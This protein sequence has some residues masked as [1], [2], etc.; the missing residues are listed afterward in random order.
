MQRIE[1][2]TRPSSIRC[3]LNAGMLLL[4][5]SAGAH[6][7]TITID[8]ADPE[9]TVLTETWE[10]GTSA[11]GHWDADY[12]Y[13]GTTGQ[14]YSYGEVEWRPNMPAGAYEVSIYYPQ[15]T[16]RADNAPFTVNFMG[17]SHQLSI[18]QQAD[19]GQWN[20]L[21]VYIFASGS[22]GYVTLNNDANP[23]V[24]I[25]DAVRFTRVSARVDLTMEVDPPGTGDTTPTSGSTHSRYLDEVVPISA[26]PAPGYV[27]DHWEVSTGLPVDDAFAFQTLVAVEQEKTVTAVFVETGQAPPAF[28][29]IW[30]DAFN[31]GFKSTAQIDDL[32]S[33]A[34]TGNYNAIFPEVMAYQDTG[35]GAHGA[36]WKSD[37][38]PMA[39]DVNTNALPD[40]LDY[41]VQQAHAN[42]IEVHAWL[43]AF[44]VCTSWPPAGNSLVQPEWIMV[45][46]ADM[47]GGP[48]KVDGKYT[49]DPGCPAVQ[50]YL[51]SIV[52]ELVTDYEIDGIHWDYIRYTSTDAGYPAHTWYADSGLERF[53]TI[54]GYAGTPDTSYGP[55]NDFRRR[56][57]NELIRRCLAEVHTIDS[58][59]RQP[60]RHT[61]AVFGAGNPPANFTD[62][63][64]YALF[65]NW[66]LWLELGWLDAA[67]PMNYKREHCPTHATWYR[68][69]IDAAI[70]WR[71]ERHVYCGQGNYLNSFDNSIAQLSYVYGQGANGSMNYS[72]AAT[73]ATETI[74]D[75]Y[76]NTAND[77]AWFTHLAGA[78]FTNPAETPEM[79][80]H[81]PA[82]ATRGAVYGRVTD[83]GT[84]APIDN[85]T[86]RID[87][88]PQTETDGNGY[89]LV[90]KLSAAVGGSLTEVSA[91]SAGYAEVSRPLALVERASFTEIN[92]GL[93]SWR[94]GDY[95]VDSDVD[96][97]DF[98]EFEECATAPNGGPVSAGCDI[99][100]FD[101]DDDVDLED[102]RVLQTSFTG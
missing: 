45:P 59:P 2:P 94:L 50:D 64:A 31:T 91:E 28:R 96:L 81:D 76:N 88:L 29:G 83:A 86:I 90:N 12:R 48:A 77:P 63:S 79:P 18:D 71:D 54:E 52:R 36:Y 60:L 7:Q 57:I 69:W 15:G 34:L 21:G 44:R 10:T 72:Y 24:V 25:A 78:L 42:G 32:V 100:D 40:P 56:G 70:A 27:F 74:C 101:T 38:L 33:R 14:G 68:N 66:K 35:S 26:S 43:V 5:L 84:G 6:S 87:G 58:N 17:G 97:T 47:G 49:L 22:D 102:F 73:R 1:S 99:F 51:V 4:A 53:R 16:N 65:Q 41:L 67:C 89:Y 30:V 92:L 37:I 55:W 82:T 39:S 80:W 3:G 9:F 75:E 62:T 46:Q 98:L 19:G 61:A 20:P 23:S 13:R 8:N 85:A 93:G 95:D 11:P